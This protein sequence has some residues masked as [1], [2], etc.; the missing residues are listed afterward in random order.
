MD[1]ERSY[2]ARKGGCGR[3]FFTRKKYYFSRRMT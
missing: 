1:T 2:A 3:S